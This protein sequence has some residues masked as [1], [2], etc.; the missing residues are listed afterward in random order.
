MGEMMVGD[1][2]EHLEGDSRNM[3]RMF[4]HNSVPTYTAISVTTTTP[5]QQN[6]K[7]PS[8]YVVPDKYV[9]KVEG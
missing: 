8:S 5:P 3:A 4:S 6:L 7:S 1:A 9:K 2:M